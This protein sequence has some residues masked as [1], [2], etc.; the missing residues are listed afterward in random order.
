MFMK[1]FV[2]F[3]LFGEGVGVNYAGKSTYQTK[4]GAILS[5]VSTTLVLFYT[6]TR[7][8]L[9]VTKRQPDKSSQI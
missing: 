5:L 4:V 9:L 8:E 7:I 1:K 2:T 6:V 3:D